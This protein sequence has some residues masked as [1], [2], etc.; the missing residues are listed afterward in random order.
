MRP[1]VVV[2]FHPVAEVAEVRWNRARVA[3]VAEVVVRILVEEAVEAEL[4][5][6]DKSPKN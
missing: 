3:E 6:K 5:L 1:V 4:L 2:P